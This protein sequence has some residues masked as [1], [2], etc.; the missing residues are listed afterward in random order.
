MMVDLLC[1]DFQLL[2]GIDPSPFE[3]L[4]RLSRNNQSIPFTKAEVEGYLKCRSRDF[5]LRIFD[6]VYWD[7]AS[8]LKDQKL[9]LLTR[10][11]RKQI[12]S[13]SLDLRELP[14]VHYDLVFSPLRANNYQPAQIAAYLEQDSLGQAWSRLYTYFPLVDDSPEW[15]LNLIIQA[16]GISSQ[17]LS[18]TP[19][20]ALK[21]QNLGSY[22]NH[23][24]W[25]TLDHK[26]WYPFR[27]L[28]SY[29]SLE[30]STIKDPVNQILKK[31]AQG[32]SLKIFRFLCEYFRLTYLD[33]QSR[34]RWVIV[35]GSDIGKSSHLAY[36]EERYRTKVVGSDYLW[37]TQGDH[38]IQKD[39][40][41]FSIIGYKLDIHEPLKGAVRQGHLEIVA[42]LCETYNITV[43]RFVDY[44]GQTAWGIAQS[45]GQT[46]ISNYF[47]ARAKLQKKESS[48]C[49]IS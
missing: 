42:Y 37:I 24:L 30:R 19:G 14:L 44:H 4:T 1:S 21:P 23:Y 34:I 41:P 38:Q 2:T 7:L 16:Y 26:L 22:Q 32:G 29:F 15:Q 28:I 43:R 9:P 27:Y 48:L 33:I 46:H 8:Y 25:W 45:H 13:G 5:D 20:R 49:L 11:Y 36:F 6:P 35:Y 40:C 10:K 31:A 39:S 47:K 3:E 17:H 18:L 12:L